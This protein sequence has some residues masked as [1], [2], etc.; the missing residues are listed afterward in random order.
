MSRL[1]Q[2]A[3]KRLNDISASEAHSAGCDDE[4]ILSPEEN[5]TDDVL[6]ASLHN[7]LPEDIDLKKAPKNKKKKSGGA[8]IR[9][10]LL[11]ICATVFIACAAYLVW[12][13]TDKARGN[14]MYADVADQMGDIFAEDEGDGGAVARLSSLRAAQSV[15]CLK[16]RLN[17]GDNYANAVYDSDSRI[18]EMRAKLTSLA[19]EFPDLYGWISIGGTAINYPVVQGADNEYYLNA[20]PYK[21]PLVNGSI[22]VDYRNYKEIIRNFNTVLYGHNLTGGGMFHDVQT[23]CGDE[24]LFKNSLIYVY[25]MDGAYVYE[26]FAVYEAKASYQYFRTEFATTDE[27]VNFANEM[28]SNSVWHKDVEFTATDR[29]ITLSTC[30]NR[31]VDGRYALQAKLVQV[32][33]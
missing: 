7:L 11:V 8:V 17:A 12:N 20:S 10:I 27:F 33:H 5:G 22:F 26:P 29:I 31:N 2:F 23:I 1:R 4:L 14:A 9:R 28:K 13:L 19:E 21:K 18:D 16:D 6:T 25:T 32:L 30:T 15:L 24:E 3:L